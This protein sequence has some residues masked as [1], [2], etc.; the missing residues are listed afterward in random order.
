MNPIT[1][2][3]KELVRLRKIE[4]QVRGIQRMIRDKRYCIDILTQIS[5][6]VG[7]LER[8]GESVLERHLR[9]CVENAFV[10]GTRADRA[11]KIGEIIGVLRR[12]RTP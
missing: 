2:H 12:F 4:G 10:K 7:A 6:V 1:T 11:E 9:G 3:E 5:S 8:V